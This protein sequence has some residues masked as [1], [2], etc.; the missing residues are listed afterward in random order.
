MKRITLGLLSAA[1]LCSAAQAV[2]LDL[3]IDVGGTDSF[4]TLGSASNVVRSVDIAAA[5]PGYGTYRL[6][7]IGWSLNL[8]AIS[9]SWLSDMNISIARS[10]LGDSVQLRAAAF[11]DMPGS[12]LYTSDVQ[13]LIGLGLDYELAAD[14]RVRLEFYELFDDRAGADGSYDRPSSITLRFDAKPVPEPATW[15]TLGLGAVAL[16]RRRR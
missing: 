1:M 9:P 6:V 5:F 12:G 14:N 16:L 3:T 10:D 7:G 4:D 11:D 2:L 8:T 15:A 13:D